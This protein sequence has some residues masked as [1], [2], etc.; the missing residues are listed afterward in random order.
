MSFVKTC[1]KEK[2]KKQKAIPRCKILE[3]ICEKE[4]MFVS[5]RDS[6][7]LFDWAC[8]RDTNRQGERKRE[9]GY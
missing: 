4:F 2:M 9:G 3:G 5:L 6:V 1:F 7:C 8:K